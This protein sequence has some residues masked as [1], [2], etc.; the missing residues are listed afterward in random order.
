MFRFEKL[1]VW[2][3]AVKYGI[4]IYK[5]SLI[6]P[7]SELFG[8]ISQ[9]RRA[10]VSI[11]SNIAEG[12]GSATKKEFKRFLDVAIKSTLETVSQLLFAVELGYLKRKDIDSLYLEAEV[13]I[14]R[15]H[16]FKRAL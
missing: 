3:A 8:L 4:K 1:E 5:V 12:S 14:K 7:K 13:L 15:L 6:L 16:A 9:L 2:Q 10:S 11:S